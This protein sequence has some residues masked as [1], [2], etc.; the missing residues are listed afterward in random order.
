MKSS[1]LIPDY[2]SL[3]GDGLSSDYLEGAFP[4][5]DTDA[6]LGAWHLSQLG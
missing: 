1:E 5:A 3:I 4:F 6:L 2:V